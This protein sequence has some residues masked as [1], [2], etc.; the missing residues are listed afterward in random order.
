MYIKKL[1]VNI[2]TRKGGIL[3]TDSIILYQQLKN[4]QM[5]RVLVVSTGALLSPMMTFQKE[6]IPSVAHA[7]S[8]EA[9]E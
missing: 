1:Y 7:I 4:K 6:T 9:V 5:K 8:L 2:L 3:L